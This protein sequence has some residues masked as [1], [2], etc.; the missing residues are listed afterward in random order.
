VDETIIRDDASESASTSAGECET[1]DDADGRRTRRVRG[2]K[3]KGIDTG[4]GSG[5]G[6]IAEDSVSGSAARDDLTAKEVWGRIWHE[7]S[8]RREKDRNGAYLSVIPDLANNADILVPELI[9]PKDFTDLLIH[10]EGFVKEASG[11]KEGSA[12]DHLSAFLNSG[13]V[14]KQKTKA[15][16]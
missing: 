16:N 13:D 8:E 15:P 6:A 5:S 9:Q 11:A 1:Q 12:I 7:F 2:S 10:L 4:E 14:P 3:R